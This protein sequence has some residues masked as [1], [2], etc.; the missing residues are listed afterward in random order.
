MAADIINQLADLELV[1]AHGLLLANEDN[2]RLG[3]KEPVPSNKEKAPLG[4]GGA[5]LR[6]R[7]SGLGG[8]LGAARVASTMRAKR[9]W[10]PA[11]FDFR[12][13]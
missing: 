9:C 13:G 2:A 12:S 5:S 4:E 10:F 8:A 7:A 1:V 6:Q 11:H 3:Q